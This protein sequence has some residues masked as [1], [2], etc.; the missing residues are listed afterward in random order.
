MTLTLELSPEEEARLK[1]ASRLRG[2]D[3][4]T[5]A[6]RLVTDNLPGG[7]LTVEDF[8][9]CIEQIARP[10]TSIPHEKQTREYF[11]ED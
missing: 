3:P 7:Q 9:R 2:T 11:Y 4:V 5:L 6:K 10:L 1:M 8:D